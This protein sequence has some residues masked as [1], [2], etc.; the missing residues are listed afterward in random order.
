MLARQAIRDL[1]A[2]TSL[3]DRYLLLVS[4]KARLVVTAAC[5]LLTTCL[6]AFL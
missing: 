6:H 2:T 1:F 4:P 5:R 3:P